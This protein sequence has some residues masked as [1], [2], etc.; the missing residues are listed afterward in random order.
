[1]RGRVAWPQ[2]AAAL[3]PGTPARRQPGARGR[4]AEP[5]GGAARQPQTAGRARPMGGRRAAGW[6][7]SVT[8]QSQQGCTGRASWRK[9]AR[10]WMGGQHGGPSDRASGSVRLVKGHQGQGSCAAA[11]M[12]VLAHAEPRSARLGRRVRCPVPFFASSCRASSRGGG[13][14]RAGPFTKPGLLAMRA[15]RRAAAAGG[16]APAL[17]GAASA[18]AGPA[19]GG[20]VG[21]RWPGQ[22]V[23]VG[24]KETGLDSG[25]SFPLGFRR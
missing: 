8:D 2:G 24:V 7:E 1:V 23:Q 10:A 25:P 4:A 6:G 14:R 12:R 13:V 3:R 21:R 19:A 22:G 11:C 20:D 15:L 9:E 17:A 16:G 5:G 18:A